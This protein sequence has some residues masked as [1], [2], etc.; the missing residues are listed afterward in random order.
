V[1]YPRERNPPAD[2]FSCVFRINPSGFR[3]L[4]YMKAFAGAWS[5]IAMLQMASAT[6]PW[7]HHVLLLEKLAVPEERLWYM[8]C[9]IKEGW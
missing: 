2:V 3:N 8:A 4:R 9:A 7:S 5:D 1:E 6:L